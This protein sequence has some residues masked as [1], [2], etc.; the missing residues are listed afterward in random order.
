MLRILR[1]VQDQY[2]NQKPDSSSV[3]CKPEFAVQVRM[4]E[5]DGQGGVVD[6]ATNVIC[7]RLGSQTLDQRDGSAS[8]VLAVQA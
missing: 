5:T 7:L 8:K 2:Q 1:L 3:F 4:R 6:R